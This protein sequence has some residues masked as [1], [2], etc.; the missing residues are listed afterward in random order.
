MTDIQN[1]ISDADRLATARSF[2]RH[3]IGSDAFDLKQDD[4]S[5]H[6][7][8]TTPE[9]R[10]DE[11]VTA[12]DDHHAEFSVVERSVRFELKEAAAIISDADRLANARNFVRDAIGSDAFEL[13]DEGGSYHVVL[14]DPDGRIDEL[15]TAL[16]EHD[17]EFSVVER[18]VRFM[19][20]E[21]TTIEYLIALRGYTF[22]D[23]MTRTILLRHSAEGVLEEHVDGGYV[24]KIGPV[25]DDG[26]SDIRDDLE[27]ATSYAEGEDR[28]FHLELDER[29]I[30]E[31]R[32]GMPTIGFHVL[33]DTSSRATV[34]S[35]FDGANW[36]VPGSEKAF[37]PEDVM[38]PDGTN[39]GG[40]FNRRR[41]VETDVGGANWQ[42]HHGRN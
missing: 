14:T 17:A 6:L 40:R 3:A 7:V 21:D 15:V 26:L 13:N 19:L 41:F 35:H 33:D 32:S 2:A 11:L 10:V 34:V 36:W 1:T 24:L 4:G 30:R 16:D 38:G 18:S 8:L 22:A 28:T 27:R 23:Q 12:L 20:E 39:A 42:A 5:Y 25:S 37:G 31:I 9:G 29:T